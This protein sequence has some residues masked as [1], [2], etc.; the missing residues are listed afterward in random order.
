MANPLSPLLREPLTYFL[1]AGAAI[2]LVWDRLQDERDQY[3]IEI[4]SQERARIAAQWEAQMG[5]APSA[6]EM[7]GLLDQFIREEIYYREALRIG[8]DRNDTIIRRRLAQKLGFLTEDIAAAQPATEDELRAYYQQHLTRY[9]EPEKFSFQHRYFSAERRTDAESD[10]AQA[11]ATLRQ[12]QESESDPFMLQSAFAGRSQRQVADLFGS[13][14]ARGLTELDP[15][16]WHGPLRSAYGWHAVLVQARSEP[17]QQTFEE[18][19]AR[20][21]NDRN[22]AIRNQANEDYYQTLKSRYQVVNR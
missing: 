21:A 10:A 20:V 9:R 4:S 13:E 1:L 11:V 7:S 12:G 16:T 17:R 14:F 19:T 6:D 15:D 8:L 5:R 3:R 22:Q 18:V 2:F